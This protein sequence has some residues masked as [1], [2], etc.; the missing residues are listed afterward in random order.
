VRPT[1]ALLSVLVDASYVLECR[2][3]VALVP[4]A[5]APQSTPSSTPSRSPPPSPVPTECKRCHL[6]TQGPCQPVASQGYVCPLPEQQS[7]PWRMI[8]CGAG[9]VCVSGNRVDASVPVPCFN[10]DGNTG[11]C[12][13]G[14]YA[15]DCPSCSYG[16]AGPCHGPEGRCASY[17]STVTPG[18]A[19]TS[20][21]WCPVGYY[22]CGA[23]SPSLP[24]PRPC[25]VCRAGSV[26]PCQQPLTGT[27]YDYIE[28]TAWAYCT[29]CMCSCQQD[30]AT[31]WDRFSSSLPCRLPCVSPGNQG[32][33]VLRPRTHT[34]IPSPR[35]CSLS[36]HDRPTLSTQRWR[37]CALRAWDQALPNWSSALPR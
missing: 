17:D 30:N 11:A 22:T 4:C 36:G 34:V 16:T 24:T 12:P 1:G 9:A 31:C 25:P 18:S 6:G 37:L 7:R 13:K 5:A 26:G 2:T 8:M 29:W 33:H 15:C 35:V 23:T 10:L 19:T 20:V 3:C 21:S 27:C 14:T 32:M 28:G